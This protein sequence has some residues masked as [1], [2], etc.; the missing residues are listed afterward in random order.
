MYNSRDETGPKSNSSG[1]RQDKKTKIRQRYDKD[2]FIP[3]TQDKIYFES[4]KPTK[5]NI[6]SVKLLNRLLTNK[7]YIINKYIKE[8]HVNRFRYYQIIN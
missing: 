1:I 8:L 3:P 7:L 6:S 5:F 2:I 4:A